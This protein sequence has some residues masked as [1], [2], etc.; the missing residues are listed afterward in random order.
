ME[1]IILDPVDMALLQNDNNQLN[2][3]IDKS[4][5]DGAQVGVT[6][7]VKVF[8]Y[9][10]ESGLSESEI[11]QIMGINEINYDNEEIML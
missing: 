5:I 4:K 10:F 7:N 9:L 11:S 8:N 1:E 6:W 2:F 3:I